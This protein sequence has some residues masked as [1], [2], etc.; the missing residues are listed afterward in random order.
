MYEFKILLEDNYGLV[1]EK[2]L[3]FN[4]TLDKDW[5]KEWLRDKGIRDD[6]RLFREPVGRIT[7]I[8]VFGEVDVEFNQSSTFRPKQ[9][10]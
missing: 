3:F 1:T 2:Y 5:Y 6:L 9:F 7:H 4:L 10:L 8:S